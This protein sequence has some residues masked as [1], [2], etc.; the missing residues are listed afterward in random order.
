MFERCAA[1]VLPSRAG[2]QLSRP[3]RTARSQSARREAVALEAEEGAGD[4]EEPLILDGVVE[5][6]MW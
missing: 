5:R 2:H 4:L 3:R 6:A 1:P